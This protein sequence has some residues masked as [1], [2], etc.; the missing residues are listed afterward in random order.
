M[1]FLDPLEHVYLFRHYN[2]FRTGN[3][4]RLFARFNLKI[5]K[6][7]VYNLCAYGVNEHIIFGY[8]QHRITIILCS[9]YYSI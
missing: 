8:T 6:N 1:R 9:S 5:I 3:N 2:L 4:K 7:L